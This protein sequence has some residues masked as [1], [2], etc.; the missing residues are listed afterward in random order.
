MAEPSAASSGDA[1]PVIVT[2]VVD[3]VGTITLNRPARR[4]ALNGELISALDSAVRQMAEDP[5]AKVIVLTGAAPEGGARRVLLRRRREGRRARLAGQREGCPGRRAVRRPVPARPPCGHAAA[6][7]AEADHR[8]GGGPGSRR[9]LQPRRCVRPALRVRGRR[10]LD[11][12]LAQRAV[13]R[14]RGI[15]LLDAHRRHGAG[16]APLPAQREDP[17]GPGARARHGA[18]RPPPG[19]APALHRRRSRN[20]SCARRPPCWRS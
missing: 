11:E 4:N 16:T 20:A 18:R 10:V 5:A 13:G 15:I 7:H 9:R 14:L 8:H 6:P 1:R 12:L 2:E 19:R 3:R 17:C